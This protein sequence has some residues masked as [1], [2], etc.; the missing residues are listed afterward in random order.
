MDE[1]FVMLERHFSSKQN[2][3]QSLTYLKRLSFK[4]IKSEKWCSDIQA[5]SIA[6]W[7]ILQHVPQCVP[8][9]QGGHQ[10]GH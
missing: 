1:A 5:L 9:Y 7:R 10:D 8:S 2:H 4:A 3:S 6:N